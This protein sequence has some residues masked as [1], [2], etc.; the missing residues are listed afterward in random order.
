MPTVPYTLRCPSCGES[1]TLAVN[2]LRCTVEAVSQQPAAW[3]ATARHASLSALADLVNW[4]AV[5]DA[6]ASTYVEEA[7]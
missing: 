7:R 5:D 1:I 6:L 4:D 3:C 2:P